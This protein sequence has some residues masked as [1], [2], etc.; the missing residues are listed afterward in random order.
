VAP[1]FDADLTVLTTDLHVATTVVGGRE[2]RPAAEV[3]AWRS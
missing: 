3:A 2:V 1:G